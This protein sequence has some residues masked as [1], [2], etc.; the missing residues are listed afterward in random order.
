MQ[1][2][3]F[4]KSRMEVLWHPRRVAMVGATNSMMKWGFIILSR[5]LNEGFEGEVYPVN[6]RD[7]VILGK[8]AYK[9]INDVPVPVDVAVVVTPAPIVPAVLKECAEKG[10][11]AAVVITSGF[12]ET[13]EQGAEFEREIVKIG[14]AAGMVTVGPNT[15]GTYSADAK[16]SCLMAPVSPMP[17]RAAC[18]SQS[19]NI[20]THMLF[21]GRL[22]K[23]GFGKFVSSGNE[24]DLTFEDYLWY[25]GQDPDTNAV[26]GYLEGLDPGSD[27]VEI[28]SEVTKKK[29]VIILKGGRTRAGASAAASHTGTLAGDRSL[30]EAAM[31]QAG[32]IL[33]ESNK[34]VVEL[35]RAMELVPVPKGPRIGI[36]TRGGGWGVITSDACEEA[37]LEVVKLSELTISKIDKILP[38]YWSRGNPVDMVAVISYQT[39]I[40]CLEI[41]AADPNVD[42]LIT[43]G[44]N[45]DAQGITMLKSLHKIGVL[46][47]EQVKETN[48]RNRELTA[49]FLDTFREFC[50]SSDKPVLSV[51]RWLDLPEWEEDMMMI[52]EPE[53]AARMM[54]K[55]VRYGQY[56]DRIESY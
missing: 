56:L 46:T 17:G 51:G 11:P 36:L 10:V 8:K 9:S 40:D 54:A 32:V 31:R 2:K 38:P 52:G 42:A 47:G 3:Q 29:P 14:R 55:M 20:G 26:L 34:E 28:A 1:D 48:D 25:F 53:D 13:G 45:I 6:P 15:M 27:F 16:F 7:H 35:A 44:A 5:M 41:L 49:K 39:Y 18:I 21:R 12:S 4:L 24:G 22:R 30:M 33:A 19:G 50:R 43:L 37:G 23:L